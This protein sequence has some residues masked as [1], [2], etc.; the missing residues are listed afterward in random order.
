[1]FTTKFS[2]FLVIIEKVCK[3]VCISVLF[4]SFLKNKLVLSPV[5]P[6]ETQ[7][8]FCRY[9]LWRVK[10]PFPIAKKGF[11]SQE[12]EV[13]SHNHILGGLQTKTLIISFVELWATVYYCY[14]LGEMTWPWFFWTSHHTVESQGQDLGHAWWSYCRLLRKLSSGDIVT[15]KPARKLQDIVK[16]SYLQKKIKKLAVLQ[17]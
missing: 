12:A 13:C 16:L 1:M 15:E 10:A 4:R 9:K 6:E 17:P 8:D 3:N 7:Q 14:P 2:A 11:H 5:A